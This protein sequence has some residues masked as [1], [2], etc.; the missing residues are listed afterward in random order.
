MD[1]ATQAEMISRMDQA[2]AHLR[3]NRQMVLHLHDYLCT[4]LNKI[5]KTREFAEGMGAHETE[6]S[7]QLI[8]SEEG[9]EVLHQMCVVLMCRW[10]L[11]ILEEQK[12]GLGNAGND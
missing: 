5:H 10:T 11:E 4:C 3:E 7:L 1:I 8:T 2:Y 9:A 12:D 6:A